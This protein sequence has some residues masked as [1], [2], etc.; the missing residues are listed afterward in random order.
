MDFSGYKKRSKSPLLL[1]YPEKENVDKD[2]NWS[3]GQEKLVRQW[4]EQAKSYSWMHNYVSTKWNNFHNGMNITQITLA[5]SA[6]LGNFSNV[7][8]TSSLAWG[9]GL[10]AMG[11]FIFSGIITFK[12]YKGLATFHKRS[13]SKFKG[14]SGDIEYQLSL[15][16]ENRQNGSEFMAECKEVY[17]ALTL[18]APLI[19][20]WAIEKYNKLFKNSKLSKPEITNNLEHIIIEGNPS[21][22][23]SAVK[24]KK[25]VNKWK[26]DIDIEGQIKE[27]VNK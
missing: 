10:L 24:M 11:S 1:T 21:P 27:M 5:G 8:C 16:R 22:P 23:D 6:S 13:S 18:E 26:S 19:P 2:N 7:E 20:E 3:N 4:G 15:K 14:L 9:L 12:D 17:D 25:M